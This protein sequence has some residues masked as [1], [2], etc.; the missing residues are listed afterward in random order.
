[1]GILP[2]WR[3]DE[4]VGVVSVVTDLG[5]D[6]V[7]ETSTVGREGVPGQA[8][9]MSAEALRRHLTDVDSALTSMLR[10]SASALFT[11]LSRNAACNRVHTVRERAARWPLMTA[12]RMDNPSFELTQHF[13]AQMLAVRRT[14]VSELAQSLAEDGCITYSRGV[15]TIVDRPRL[16]SHAC[17]C[18]EVIRRATDAVLAAH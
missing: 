7:V 9:T 1:M 8:L 18:Y 11:Q 15:I 5:A 12:D 2:G 14:S 4:L 17:N 13:L 16:R 3:W 10:R 6:R